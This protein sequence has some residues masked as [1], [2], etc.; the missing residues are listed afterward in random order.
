VATG[1]AGERG[2]DVR[3]RP[4][5]RIAAAEIEQWRSAPASLVGH[6]REERHEIL[7]RQPLQAFRP[8]THPEP[9]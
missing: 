1:G 7:L 5:L 9:L 3:R 2:D 4:D 8:R 6:A